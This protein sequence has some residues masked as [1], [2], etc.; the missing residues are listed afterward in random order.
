MCDRVGKLQRIAAPV[1]QAVWV[2]AVV[3]P[4]LTLPN[5]GNWTAGMKKHFAVWSAA[6]GLREELQ[7]CLQPIA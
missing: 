2:R 3:A 7:I 5:C 6:A 4:T 1:Q